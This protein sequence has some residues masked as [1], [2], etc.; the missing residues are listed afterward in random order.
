M[1]RFSLVS[2]CALLGCWDF[3]ALN[4]TNTAPTD[5]SNVDSYFCDKTL[6]TTV[7]DCTNGI[8]DNDDCRVDCDDPTCAGHVKCFDPNNKLLGYGNKV[9]TNVTC[10]GTQTTTAINQNLQL[11][12]DCSAGCACQTGTAQTCASKLH[13]FGGATAQADC[14]GNTNEVGN[15]NLL[16]SNGGTPTNDCDAITM[17]ATTNY[18]K[19]DAITSTC[20]VDATKKGT[21]VA[22]WQTQSKLC[23]TAVTPTTCQDLKCMASVGNCVA[24]GGDYPTCPSMFPFRSLWYTG[25]TDTRTCTCSCAAGAGSCAVSGTQALFTDST[26]CP[27]GGNPKTSALTA[28]AMCVQSNIMTNTVAAGTLTFQARP[29]CQASGTAPTDIAAETAAGRIATTGPVTLCCT[30]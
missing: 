18:F 2:L 19:L 30:Q 26:S 9:A 20:P 13:W 3:A 22:S 25:Y 29:V 24:Y 28:T 27:V 8:D 10:P 23:S 14:M 15:A 7:E 12:A 11:S 4:A 17:P 5:G 1:R 21:N 16:S 6:T